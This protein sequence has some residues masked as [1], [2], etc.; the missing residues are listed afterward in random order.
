MRP[1]TGT[2][3]Y[4]AGTAQCSATS[5]TITL[6]TNIFYA[7]W[8]DIGVIVTIVD[9]SRAAGSSVGVTV[10]TVA[11]CCVSQLESCSGVTRC[12]ADLCWLLTTGRAAPC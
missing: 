11:Q 8:V 7:M 1:D 12:S 3:Y 5:W 6:H 10:T 2:H 4:D 9:Q